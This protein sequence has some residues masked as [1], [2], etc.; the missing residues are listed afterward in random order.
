M[1]GPDA[2][3]GG[4]EGTALHSSVDPGLGAVITVDVEQV[5][6][7]PREATTI[8]FGPGGLQGMS[9]SHPYRSSLPRPPRR[10]E[11]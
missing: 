1:E 3:R 8:V 4:P 5:N 11:A 10:H 9:S 6:R 7:E 2:A